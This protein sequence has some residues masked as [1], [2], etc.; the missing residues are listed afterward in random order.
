MPLVA[1]CGCV[2]SVN[3]RLYV[4]TEL[5]IFAALTPDIVHHPT[6]S[7]TDPRL[8][9]VNGNHIQ[10]TIYC[11]GLKIHFKRSGVISVIFV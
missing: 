8:A 2:G 7:E 11:N 10:E 9:T 4:S 5:L 6:S 1:A 3:E